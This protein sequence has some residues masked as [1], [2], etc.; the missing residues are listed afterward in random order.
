M[1]DPTPIPVS[2]DVSAAQP[3][4]GLGR[5]LGIVAVFATLVVIVM[6]IVLR[7]KQPRAAHYV[8]LSMLLFTVGALGVLLRRNALVL[9]MCVELMLNAVNI[10]FVAFARLNGVIGGQVIVLFVM[11]VAAAEVAVGL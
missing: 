11:I 9:F 5:V 3:G 2:E 8:G 10:A 1:A 7:G 6:A 4:P